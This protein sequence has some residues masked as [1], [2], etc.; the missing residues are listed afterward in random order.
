[1]NITLST[2]PIT[3]MNSPL[4]IIDSFKISYETIIIYGL[5]ALLIFIGLAVW[6]ITFKRGG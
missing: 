5:I 6:I 2:E 1:M 3:N 4:I